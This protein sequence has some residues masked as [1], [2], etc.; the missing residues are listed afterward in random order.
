MSPS[1]Q[2]ITP[3]LLRPRWVQAIVTVAWVACRWLRHG[4]RS[5]TCGDGHRAAL[6]TVGS[7]RDKSIRSGIWLAGEL[8]LAPS[9]AVVGRSDC[10]TGRSAGRHGPRTFVPSHHCR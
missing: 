9:D 6:S 3:E 2:L 1:Q 4:L 5:L 8:M 10:P 7:M